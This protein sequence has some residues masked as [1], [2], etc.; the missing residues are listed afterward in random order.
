MKVDLVVV[1]R[2]KCFD[3]LKMEVVKEKVLSENLLKV[4]K[5]KID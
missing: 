1:K 3:K 5:K 4:K 2:P